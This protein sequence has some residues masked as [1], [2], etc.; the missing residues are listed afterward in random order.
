MTGYKVLE[1]R[2][3]LG[4]QVRPNRQHVGGDAAVDGHVGLAELVE[5]FGQ[6][7]FGRVV[8]LEQIGQLQLLDLQPT[9]KLSH[10]PG[11]ALTLGPDDLGGFALKPQPS[12]QHARA[13]ASGAG[14]G[15]LSAWPGGLADSDRH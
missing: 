14:P 5:L 15:L 11:K 6:L 4:V 7:L 2:P 8:G 12:D 13:V 10:V 9:L 3:L 1:L